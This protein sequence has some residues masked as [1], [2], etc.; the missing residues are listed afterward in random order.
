[1][2]GR[3]LQD[4]VIT[5]RG[6]DKL[7]EAGDQI[8]ESS[9]IDKQSI[10]PAPSWNAKLN[11]DWRNDVGKTVFMRMLHWGPL[12]ALFLIFYIGFVAAT[13]ALSWWPIST[14]GGFVH[15]SIFL[16]WNYSTL[17]NFLKAA[18]IGGG[19]LT[20]EWTPD[21]V[22]LFIQSDMAGH[23]T[24]SLQEELDSHLQYCSQC[25]GYK[26]PRAHHCSKCQRCV[27]KMDHHC[28]WI[29]N[30]VGHRNHAY[31]VIFLAS[32]STGCMH[33]CVIIATSIYHGL[34]LTW[35]N[36]YAAKDSYPVVHLTISW[37]LVSVLAAALAA[38]VSVAV[39]ILMG[40]QLKGIYKGMT[41]L[42]D[43]IVSKAEHS[44]EEEEEEGIEVTPFVFPYDL[45]WKSNMKEIFSGWGTAHGN[46]I[47]WPIRNGT[48]Q[49]TLT[50]EQL[51][52]KVAKRERARMVK[53]I[54]SYP[55]GWWRSIFV[56]IRVF[57]CQPISEEAR[58][59]IEMEELWMVTRGQKHWLY[60]KKVVS[61]GEESTK[62]WFPRR[63]AD[64]VSDNENDSTSQLTIAST[65]Q[66]STEKSE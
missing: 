18:F 49:F 39:G 22:T 28:P 5:R 65:S 41:A 52:Q 66:S 15:F 44:R 24:C 54:H 55:G 59:K 16:F 43:Y 2:V 42:E 27:L 63:Y 13:L 19:Y 4:M 53:I 34:N 36:R 45:G 37:F 12:I 14:V 11:I 1:R 20:K 51:R 32:A 10:I 57:L 58:V 9:K 23:H 8:E 50:K 56:G 17:N 46:G 31:F 25:K 30:C 26:A 61:D 29:N 7:K 33:A 48:D 38:G 40:I 47:W 21:V 6:K 3:P 62:G 60:G 35:Y 64:I